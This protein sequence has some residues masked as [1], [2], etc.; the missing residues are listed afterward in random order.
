VSTSRS[1]MVARKQQSLVVTFSFL[2]AA[3]MQS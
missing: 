1:W 3:Q 2:D